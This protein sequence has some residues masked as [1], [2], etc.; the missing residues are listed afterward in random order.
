VPLHLKSYFEEEVAKL[1][2]LGIVVI[3][4]TLLLARRIGKKSYTTYR[5][6]IVFRALNAVTAFE[7]EPP[8]IIEEELPKFSEAQFF[9][10]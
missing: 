3:Q 8:C 6:A 9:P 7:A 10:N 2:K 5:L 1:L 4:I